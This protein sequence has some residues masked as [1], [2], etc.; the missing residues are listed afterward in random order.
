[1]LIS[2]CYYDCLWKTEPQ[3]LLTT[4]SELPLCSPGIT[5]LC[6]KGHLTSKPR[7]HF[8]FENTVIWYHMSN[9]CSILFSYFFIY[10]P[11]ITQTQH[12][13]KHGNHRRCQSDAGQRCIR[14]N[15]HKIRNRQSNQERLCKS[16]HH[17]K[18]RAGMSVEISHKA[19]QNT[20]HNRF[21]G[22]AAQI[23][24]SSGNVSWIFW[25]TP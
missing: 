14:L 25:A 13:T 4:K 2:F 19:E 5:P 10:I 17:Y 22:K 3:K 15:T 12:D 20:G 23:F 9:K 7:I 1:M 18:E 16:L 6:T 21:R 11:I 8:L 24:E